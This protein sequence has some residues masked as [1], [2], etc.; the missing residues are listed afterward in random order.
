ML[1][2]ALLITDWQLTPPSTAWELRRSHDDRLSLAAWNRVAVTVTLRRTLR[3]LAVWLRDETPPTFAISDAQRI[4]SGTA[5][6]GETTTLVY[7]LRP[8][9]RGDYAFG[10]LHLR[11]D[12]ALGLLRR[13]ARFPAAE[14]VKVY[15][16]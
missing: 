4:L 7:Y 11:W 13:Q 10:D 1:V 6:P 14:P 5:T 2:C 8:P 3:P 16:M 12:S 9:R 15:P